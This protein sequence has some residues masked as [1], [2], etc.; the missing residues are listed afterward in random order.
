MSAIPALF[1]AIDDAAAE[2]AVVE[3]AQR[4]LHRL[5]RRVLEGDVELRPVHV[6]HATRWTRPSST[7]LA[8]A[9]MDVV[10]STRGSGAW[11]R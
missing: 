8:S 9:R 7:S 4:D 5:D 1:T 10:H 11:R 6:A 3:A 2:G